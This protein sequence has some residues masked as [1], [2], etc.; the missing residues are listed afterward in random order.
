[1]NGLSRI[2]A[3]KDFQSEK[4]EDQKNSVGG[5][6]VTTCNILACSHLPSNGNRGEKTDITARR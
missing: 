4:E 6:K 2:L 1:M 3:D 5:K